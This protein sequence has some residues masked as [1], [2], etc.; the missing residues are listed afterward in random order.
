M[1]HALTNSSVR[2]HA[3]IIFFILTILQYNS[4]AYN[5]DSRGA[6]IFSDPARV[7]GTHS[8]YFGFSVAL[9][10]GEESSMLLV[11]APRANSNELKNVKEPGVVYACK[12]DGVCKEWVIDK[13]GNGLHK[14]VNQIKDGA[15]IGATIAVQ[16]ETEARVVVC[17]YLFH[18]YLFIIFVTCT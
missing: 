4:S 18:L 2:S 13:S 11:G 7:L 8:S 3:R 9:Y 12:M 10:A 14:F 17:S 16:N 15:W 5:I 1:L 6:K